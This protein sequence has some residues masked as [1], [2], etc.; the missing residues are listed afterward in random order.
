MLT[1]VA[2][3]YLRDVMS[4]YETNL[5]TMQTPERSRMTRNL[6]LCL[7]ISGYQEKRVVAE[8]NHNASSGRI[9]RTYRRRIFPEKLYRS[10]N[11]PESRIGADGGFN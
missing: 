5:Y 3:Q 6:C 10:L 8:Q 7:K 9:W 11:V 2:E 1:K 4:R